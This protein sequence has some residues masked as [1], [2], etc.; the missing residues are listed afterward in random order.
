MSN[1]VKNIKW[2]NYLKCK[3]CK[4]F[5]P[6]WDRCRYKHNDWFMWVLWRCKVC[7]KEWR[8]T[9]KEL[10]MARVRDTHRYVN[11]KKRRDYLYESAKIRRNKY[12]YWA[13]HLACSRRIKKI[14]IRPIICPICN[15]KHKRIESHHF[16]Y[17]Q[18]RKI[19]F[20]C[21]ICH[22][23]LDR[24]IIKS[25]SCNII[26]IEP[27]K[28]KSKLKWIFYPSYSTPWQHEKLQN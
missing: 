13:I 2:L 11:N 28:Y 8:K 21:S 10:C 15:L 23:K 17:M 20:A 27:T 24:W 4:T 1:T 22:S 14:W 9:E 16:D 19:I 12:W 18:P 25:S 26:D 7:I 3:E 6:L 5:Q